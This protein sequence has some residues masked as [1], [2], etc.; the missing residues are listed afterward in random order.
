[1]EIRMVCSKL[2]VTRKFRTGEGIVLKYSD[3]AGRCG[4]LDTCLDMLYRSN[5]TTLNDR[6]K[7]KI[8]EWMWNKVIVASYEI[9]RQNLRGQS[10]KNHKE[11]KVSLS[12]SRPLNPQT[13]KYEAGLLPSQCDVQ[14]YCAT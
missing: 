5:H 10:E 9:L 13:P 2:A 8:L 12:V 3:I 6:I 14:S 4:I 7:D 1:M 11:P